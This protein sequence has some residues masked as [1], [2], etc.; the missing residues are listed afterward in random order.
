MK[1][2]VVMKF[3]TTKE[4]Q[5]RS[6]NKYKLLI[7][8]ACLEAGYSTDE[9]TRADFESVRGGDM[10][11]HIIQNL[12]KAE[13]VIV[14]ITGANPNVFYELGIRHT[15]KKRGTLV[16]KDS[17]ESIPFDIAKQYIHSYEF[18]IDVL[19]R[20]VASLSDL[21]KERR[22]NEIDTPVHEW[23]NLPSDITNVNIED[24]DTQLDC[25]RKKNAE[26]ENCI[27]ELKIKIGELMKNNGSPNGSKDDELV[28]DFQLAERFMHN[29]GTA[30]IQRL[31]TCI[32]EDNVQ[33]FQ[34]ELSVLQENIEYVDA[35][36]FRVIADL[37]K[38]MK[39]IPYQIVILEY[40]KKKFASNDKVIIDLINAYNNSPSLKD[41]EKSLD[42]MEEYFCI[43]HNEQGK[44]FFQRGK[45]KERIINDDELATIF[46]TYIHRDD[47]DSLLSIALSAHNE[48]EIDSPIINRNLATAYRELGQHDKAVAI[49]KEVIRESPTAREF[50]RL[51]ESFY[52]QRDFETG[53]KLAELAVVVEPE[54]VKCWIFLAIGV[55]NY[56]YAR[57]NDGV[58]R[59]KRKEA[60]KYIA[61]ILFKAIEIDK[62]IVPEVLRVMLQAG[63]KKESNIV[64]EKV[65]ENDFQFEDCVDQG[66][67]HMEILDYISRKKDS[68]FNIENE[69]DSVL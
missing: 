46:N 37:C 13:L 3:G 57:T 18:G 47:Y 33:K 6:K 35:S 55:Y 11:R 39:F 17:M 20:E 48:L 45:L 66:L 31:T 63:G 49:S 68:E 44:P 26:L 67:Y 51:S 41:K 9:V 30:I 25:L 27:S 22:T 60:I 1:C 8:S 14:D 42:I 64:I 32:A 65:A 56:Q 62:D 52:E 34:N 59:I 12:A 10:D 38:Q 69:L 24:T 15:L 61:P 19:T 21:I 36:D 29:S 54:D 2:F 43:S 23:L 28:I 50:M 40:A 58:N 53:Y 16:I 5:D 4:E 7:E